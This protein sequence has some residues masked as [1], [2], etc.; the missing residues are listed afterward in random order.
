MPFYKLCHNRGLEV[1]WCNGGKSMKKPFA[2]GV[3]SFTGDQLFIHP[4][5]K[6]PLNEVLQ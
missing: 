3:V 1:F 6:A 2:S 4:Q 5:K